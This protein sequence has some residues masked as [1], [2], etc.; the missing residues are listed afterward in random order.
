MLA[1]KSQLILDY[2]NNMLE[3][4]G[5]PDGTKNEQE[6]EDQEIADWIM[7]G[8]TEGLTTFFPSKYHVNGQEFPTCFD[9]DGI[10]YWSSV[11][12]D[13]IILQYRTELGQPTPLFYADEAQTPAAIYC[14]RNNDAA[15]QRLTGQANCSIKNFANGLVQWVDAASIS[16]IDP[17][18]LKTLNGEESCI[19]SYGSWVSRKHSINADQPQFRTLGKKIDEEVLERKI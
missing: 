3:F 1:N 9:K 5:G 17:D 18:T 13:K 7:Q 12:C 2:R 19:F 10:K 15:E 8:M 11:E 6:K 4:T 14:Y 16:C